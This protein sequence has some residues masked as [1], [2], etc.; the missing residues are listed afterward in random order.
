MNQNPPRHGLRTFARSRPVR[1]AEHKAP[2]WVPLLCSGLA[3]LLAVVE[4]DP[5]VPLWSRLAMIA[6]AVSA[7]LALAHSRSTRKRDTLKDAIR[8]WVGSA[9]ALALFDANPTP[10]L[11]VAADTARIVA[12]NPAAFALYGYPPKQLHGRL[13]SELGESRGSQASAPFSG[14]HRHRRHDGSNLHVELIVDRVHWQGNDAWFIAVHDV[15][16]RIALALDLEANERRFREI[17]ES[18]LGM[19]FIHDMDGRLSLVNGAVAN[20]LG[21]RAEEL[22]GRLLADLVPSD[23]RDYVTSYMQ[24]IRDSGQDTGRGRIVAR[25]GTEQVWEFRNRVCVDAQGKSEV[26]CCAIDISDRR[27]YELDLV[28]TTRTDP[29]TGCYN[30]RYL[31]W[32]SARALADADWGCVVIDI[33]R[34]K[35]F[36]DLHGHAAGDRALVDTVQFLGHVVREGDAVVRLGGDEFLIL[37]RHCDDREL[38]AFAARLQRAHDEHAPVRLSFGVASRVA[39]ETLERTIERADDALLRERK[40]RGGCDR[41]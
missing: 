25:D 35:R 37:L 26:L 18:T 40:R 16:A 23:Q 27:N 19:V 30:R 17:F 22:V 13:F 31:D 2:A 7:S 32:F 36:N 38:A 9:D 1:A 12:A 5:P 20:A 39:G 28:E 24:R 10:S 21:Y 14:L 33:D 11:L 6:L 15:T 4:F 3:L 34:F 41:V 8:S 29:L